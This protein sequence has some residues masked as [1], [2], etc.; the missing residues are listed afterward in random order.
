[1]KLSA[2]AS[3]LIRYVEQKHLKQKLPDFSPGDTVRVTLRVPEGDK[4]RTQI[5]EGVVISR[6][7]GGSREMVTVRKISFGVGVE[8]IFPLHSPFMKKIELVRGSRSRRAKLFYL[9]E[10]TGKGTKLKTDYQQ[11]TAQGAAETGDETPKSG[12]EASKS[13]D[14]AGKSEAAT[15]KSEA[16]TAK[17]AAAT[18]KSEAATAK[19]EAAT[20]ESAAARKT[21]PAEKAKAPVAAPEKTKKTKPAK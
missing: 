20:A 10:R 8:R 4:E 19:S 3:D 14:E 5:F 9:R 15:A 21:A 12:D 11:A 6:R 18:A 13:G 2:S 17:S 1:M 7:G 16:A